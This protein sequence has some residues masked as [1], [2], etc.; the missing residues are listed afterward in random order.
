MRINED[1]TTYK[2]PYTVVLLDAMDAYYYAD[3]MD[4][5]EEVAKEKDLDKAI[6]LADTL[7]VE[8][9][10]GWE[11]LKA[12]NE[13]DAGYD[14]RVYDG[15][16][17]CVYAAHTKYIETWI[18][19][20]PP[21]TIPVDAEKAQEEFD[22]MLNSVVKDIP[23]AIVLTTKKYHRTLL[24]TG[25]PDIKDDAKPFRVLCDDMFHYQDSDARLFIGAF[26]TREEAV[27]KCQAI[28]METLSNLYEPGMTE[29]ALM[30]KWW[31]FGDDPW[32]S[33]PN[34]NTDN[35]PFSADKEA[36]AFA[37][38]IIEQKEKELTSDN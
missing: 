30:T 25:E 4:K 16:F 5:M 28:L 17:S 32:V 10:Q 15:M 23:G 27:E 7:F 29:E 31:S 3:V 14:V 2:P 13:L 38:F 35:I 6:A 18:S 1:K 11:S 37:R 26:A 24:A 12:M 36:P 19:K 33:G 9:N 21:A 22:A 34:H 8:K 20:T